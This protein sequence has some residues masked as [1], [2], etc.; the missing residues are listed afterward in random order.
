MKTLKN[1]I[2][3]LALISSGTLFPLSLFKWATTENP[4]M[5]A[6]A[7]LMLFGFMLFVWVMLN[8][9]EKEMKNQ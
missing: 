3:I 8:E 1:L 5:L 2:I 7:F 4:Y 6:F 9:V